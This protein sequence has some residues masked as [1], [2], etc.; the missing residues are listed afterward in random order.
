MHFLGDVQPLREPCHF[1]II[2]LIMAKSE[3]CDG[4]ELD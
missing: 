1:I 3:H 4:R 2:N